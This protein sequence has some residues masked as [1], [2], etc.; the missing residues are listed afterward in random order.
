[1]CGPAAL[2]IAALVV[3]VVGTGFS[4]LQASQ[5][6]KYQAKVADRN[7][8]L[9]NEVAQQ[10]Q[11]NT[12]QE[13]LTFYRKQA[14]LKGQ[15]RAAMSANGIDVNFGSAADVQAD[16]EMLGREDVRRLYDQGAQRSR[17]FEIEA[18]NFGG[19]AN[20]ARSAASGALIGGAF[21]I[22]GQGLDY[23]MGR[24][25]Q[26]GTALSGAKQFGKVSEKVGGNSYVDPWTYGRP[27]NPKVRY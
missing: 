1:M 16:T 9:A 7:A 19:E 2:P 12:R 10:E 21:D 6:S 14:A 5:Q 8:D 3:S 15:Q 23:A 25:A 24:P 4:A 17:G 27:R 20:A 18:S 11:S 26:D 13:A 22:A